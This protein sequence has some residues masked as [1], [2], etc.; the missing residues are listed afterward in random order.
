M[1]NKKRSQSYDSHAIV[2]L[3]LFPHQ[4]NLVAIFHC[5]HTFPFPQSFKKGSFCC[6]QVAYSGSQFDFCGPEFEPFL[7]SFIQVNDLINTFS[8]L[9]ST[10]LRCRAVLERYQTLHQIILANWT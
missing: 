10:V 6:I 3:R 8:F 1:V 5:P 9:N 7:S 2:E 4:L